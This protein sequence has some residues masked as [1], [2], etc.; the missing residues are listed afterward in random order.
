MSTWQNIGSKK[1]L[2]SRLPL[3]FIILRTHHCGHLARYDLLLHL[4]GKG[5]L[6]RE[7]V[8]SV[9]QQLVLKQTILI[10]TFFRGLFSGGEWVQDSHQVDQSVAGT[11]E[12]SVQ[13]EGRSVAPETSPAVRDLDSQSEALF[14]RI[15][16]IRGW[17]D[18]KV[19][20][21]S[22]TACCHTQMPG[23]LK[24][25]KQQHR[26]FYGDLTFENKSV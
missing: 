5:I 21:G 12:P 15:W 23:D 1:R 11:R 10:S 18:C 22:L 6:Q 2:F 14:V 13:R 4:L 26:A 20:E 16:P 25:C 8:A 19:A 24:L 9:D 3:C 7:V 17:E